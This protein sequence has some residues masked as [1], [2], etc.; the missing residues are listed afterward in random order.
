MILENKTVL[1]TGAGP[2]LGNECA[3]RALRDGAS[4]VLAAR[5]Q[6]RLDAMAA[7]LGSPDRVL[8]HTA[9]VT[10]EASLTTL[11]D[12]GV[13]R[14]GAIDAAVHVAATSPLGR[15]DDVDD[16]AWRDAFEMNVLGTVHVVRA[17]LPPMKAAG[18]GSIV[19][20]GS[21]ASLKP[22]ASAPQGAY[23]SSKSALLGAARDMA[24]EFGPH[25]IRVNTVVPTWMWG[26]MVK[27]YCEWQAG[28]R[29]MTPEEIK[30]E[31]EATMALREMPT[32]GDVAEAVMFFC[33]DR[34]RMITGQRLV[35]NAGEFYDN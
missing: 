32:D 6:E 29:G 1:I 3:V 16:D 17:V 25:G 28:E 31:I 34:A 4:V 18:A 2:G 5:N 30:A 27:I 8:A 22:V 14:F 9:D 21:Q 24:E 33:S 7:E 15:F 12:A 35:V 20:I 11:V 23:G 19:L 13:E 10:D 26:P